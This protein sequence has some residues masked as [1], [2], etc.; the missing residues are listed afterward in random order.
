MLHPVSGF[1]TGTAVLSRELLCFEKNLTVTVICESMI[2]AET[3]GRDV[4]RLIVCVSLAVILAPGA[5]SQ[6]DDGGMYDTLRAAPVATAV[7]KNRD[8]YW[9]RLLNGHVDRTFERKSDLSFVAV[10]SYAREAGFG[11]GGGV[12]GLYRLDRSDSLMQPSNMSFV[13]GVSMKGFFSLTAEGNN[14]FRGNRA[15]LFY[16]VEFSNRN[17]DFWG[18]TFKDCRRNP[19]INYQRQALRVY[20]DY[21]YEACRD[22]YIGGTLDF[23]HSGA[24]RID[25]PAYLSGQRQTFTVTG[26]GISVQYDSR[27][28]VPNPEYGTCLL[29]RQTVYPG[30]YGNDG[31]NLLRTTFVTDFYRRLREGSVLAIDFYGQISSDNLPWILREELGGANRMR[32]YYRGRYIDNNII[33]GQ[34]ELRQRIYKRTGCVVWVGGG[35]VFPS[36]GKFRMNHVLPNYGVGLR[37]E[38]KH[39]VNVRIDLGF[40]KDTAGFVLNINEAWQ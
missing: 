1:S 19:V 40:G 7:R 10:P 33:S 38:I 34:I 14:N 3:A 21:R 37:F 30:D 25:D 32:G 26:M 29:L 22:F 20:A 24:V 6:P 9:R 8:S 18:I 4:K 2:V 11:I 16:R 13:A 31:R 23:L 39:K 35:T 12:V 27:D 17:L 36:P 28:F 15:A 5:W